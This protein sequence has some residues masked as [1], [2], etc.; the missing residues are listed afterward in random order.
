MHISDYFPE[1]QFLYYPPVILF[2]KQPPLMMCPDKCVTLLVSPVSAAV[3]DLL[4][5]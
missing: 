1:D 2:F 5:I 4:V 3:T